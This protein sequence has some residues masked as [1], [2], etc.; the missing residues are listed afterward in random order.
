MPIQSVLSYSSRSKKYGNPLWRGN[1]AGEV[2][3]DL[4]QYY[5]PKLFVDPAEGS[6]TSGDVA[7]ELGIEYIGLDL[8]NG[9]N[10]LKE[11]LLRRLGGRRPDYVFYHPPYA[12]IIPYSGPDGMWGREKAAHPDDLSNVQSPEEFVEKLQISLINIYDALTTKGVYSV[13]IGDVRRAGE[14]H[15]FQADIVKAAPGKLE[16]ILIKT[17]HNCVSD[18]RSYPSS[19]IRIAHEYILT[20]RKDSLLVGVIDCAVKAHNSLSNLSSATWKAVVEHALIVLDGKASLQEIYR[21]VEQNARE[22]LKSNQHWKAK[23]RQ[24]LQF[25]FE[26][27]GTGVWS[28]KEVQQAA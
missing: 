2:V 15:S 21:V 24:T 3:R 19:L 7:R 25:F 13:L 14:Y 23:V 1:C 16:G 28:R 6:G 11:H 17:Q 4:L 22:K 20:L 9:F 8:K 12:W 26:S 5:R 10:L 18:T 27:Q